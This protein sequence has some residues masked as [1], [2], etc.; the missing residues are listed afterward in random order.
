VLIGAHSSLL[1]DTANAQATANDNRSKTENWRRSA[2]NPQT[3]ITKGTM[4]PQTL[5][6]FYF[7][8]LCHLYDAENRLANALPKLAKGAS[9]KDLK[10]MIETHVEHSEDHLERLDDVFELLGEKAKGKVCHEMQG[11]IEE[12]SE[13]LAE[14]GQEATLDVGI[15]AVAQMVERYKIEAYGLARTFAEVFGQDKAVRLLQDTLDEEFEANELLNNLA[16]DM[17]NSEA[18]EKSLPAG[19]ERWGSPPNVTSPMSAQLLL[20][21]EICAYRN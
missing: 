1:E 19:W 2:I 4:K 6:T 15:I 14:E 10:E 11:L 18:L 12:G 21:G 7:D 16:E 9:S 3:G 17:V 8:E 13:I 5:R 20:R